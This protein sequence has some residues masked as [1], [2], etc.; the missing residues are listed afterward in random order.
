[1]KICIPTSHGG[2]LTQALILAESL[3]KHDIFFV[4]SHYAKPR[5]SKTKWRFIYVRNPGDNLIE[6][7]KFVLQ[8]IWIVFRENPDVILSTGSNVQIPFF[9]FGRIL[10]KKLIYIE[11][12]SRVQHPS[13][14]GK[15]L[16]KL[17]DLFFVQ[18]NSLR[19]YYPKAIYAGRLM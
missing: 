8:A 5:T 13:R 3:G 7:I 14:F 19:K 15:L 6:R 9:I 17:S 18:W 16:Y 12:W 4:T 2:H 10:N 1:M 11:S